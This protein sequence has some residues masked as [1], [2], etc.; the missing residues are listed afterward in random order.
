MREGDARARRAA[1]A[2]RGS[3]VRAARILRAATCCWRAGMRLDPWRIALAASAGRATLAGQRA[4]ARRDRRDGATNWPQP[5]PCRARGRSTIRRAP[6]WR[7]GS[8][9]RGCAVTVL[10]TVARRPRARSARP[11]RDVACDLLVTIGGASVGD[12]D[13]VKPALPRPRAR[14]D[15]RG[16][17][18][19]GPASRRG[20]GASATGGACSG[21]PATRCRRWSAPNCS[22]RRSS[23]RWRA[24]R[25]PPTMRRAR[26]AA[27][28]PANGPREHFMRATLTDDAHGALVAEA[29]ADQDSSLVSV[30]A[31]AGGLIRRLP[32]APPRRPATRSTS[33]CSI[34]EMAERVGI[35]TH[36]G[37][38]T[39]THFPG[40]R[41]R[42]LGHRSA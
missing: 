23:P 22:P 38:L 17:R 11:W 21:C 29:A 35:R 33:S 32:H 25:R 26:L 6:A 37:L 15:R 13:V 20:S 10:D 41:L 28:L 24:P 39:H 34:V 1:R 8:A 19:C 31:S 14:D 3:C 36:D 18:R 12:H 2:R 5:A 27:A 9:A 16:G 40:E 42:P 4:A 30:L 7:P